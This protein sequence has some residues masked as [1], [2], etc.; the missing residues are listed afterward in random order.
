MRLREKS[1][2]AYFNFILLLIYWSTTGSRLVVVCTRG[3][4]CWFEWTRLPHVC[5]WLFHF[6]FPVCLGHRSKTIFVH[7]PARSTESCPK[8]AAVASQLLHTL[9]CSPQTK[10]VSV[11][12]GVGE[13]GTTYSSSQSNSATIKC[14]CLKA[15]AWT[16]GWRAAQG[17]EGLAALQEADT[18]RLFFTNCWPSFARALKKF[19]DACLAMLSF[20]GFEAAEAKVKYGH[21]LTT[22]RLVFVLDWSLS[23]N[24]VV[25]TR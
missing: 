15:L 21:V 5:A 3:C 22:T 7:L 4:E 1:K 14:S 11:K 19:A 12:V 17:L 25:W 10:T 2:R 16:D 23:S 13:S 18:A 20:A 24:C 6:F 8:P 9:F